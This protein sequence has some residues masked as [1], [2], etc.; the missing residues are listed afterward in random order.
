LPATRSGAVATGLAPYSAIGTGTLIAYA[1][2]PGQTA[3]DGK[4]KDSPFTTNLLHFFPTPGPEI[5]QVLTRVR[6]EV[7]AATGNRQIPWDN[8]SLTGDVIL[9]AQDPPRKTSGTEPGGH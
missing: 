6:A 8:S 9:V 1:T 3:L 4:G 2:A 7:A 5:R